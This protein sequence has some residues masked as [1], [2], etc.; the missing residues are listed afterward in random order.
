[1]EKGC[2]VSSGGSTETSLT[3]PANPMRATIP[4][5]SSCHLFWGGRA[6]SE[7][8]SKFRVAA[9][10]EPHFGV[11]GSLFINRRIHANALIVRERRVGWRGD[12]A[13]GTRCGGDQ[14]LSVAD[15]S[16]EEAEGGDFRSGV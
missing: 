8:Q 7:P 16:D 1:M 15:S 9:F 3:E 13:S 2:D 12:Q 5:V 11:E 14:G 6:I 4:C 10:F